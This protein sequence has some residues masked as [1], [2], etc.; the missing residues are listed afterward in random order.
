MA[1]G[2]AATGAVVGAGMYFTRKRKTKNGKVVVESVK[3]R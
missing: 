2:I 1:L 3:K